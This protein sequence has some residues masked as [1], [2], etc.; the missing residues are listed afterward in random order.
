MTNL[1][2][3]FEPDRKNGRR[4]FSRLRRIP[5]RLL[6][7]NMVTLLALCAGLTSMR[8]AIEHR[9][10]L[11]IAAIAFA[12]ILDM[13]D[14]RIA[15]LLKSTS[16][17]GAELD[18]LADFV[19]FGVAPGIILYTFA[20]HEL[21]SLGWI[22]VLVLALATVLRLARFNV[23]LDA[24]PKPAWAQGFFV[25]VPAPAGAM[26]ALLP[27]YLELIGIPHLSLTAIVSSF[28]IMGVAFLMVSRLPTLSLK[29]T[30]DRVRR[31]MVLPIMIA[32]VMFVALLLSFPWTTLA[33]GSILYLAAIPVG[34]L[35]TAI[36]VVNNLRDR[37]GDARTGKRTLAVRLGA[38]GVRIE[39]SLLIAVA[40]GIPVYLF[41]LGLVGSLIFI[42]FVTFPAAAVLL[43]AVWVRDGATLNAALTGTAKL[44]LAFGLLFAL[45]ISVTT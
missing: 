14:G 30:G 2:P 11:A 18:S 6:V 36:L 7:P 26:I 35:A 21:K 43:R 17:F 28:Y 44:L 15:R 34:A 42:V 41:A 9:F 37:V 12:A 23:S 32:V 22:A 33:V 40:Y 31:D 38:T 27:I 20:L 39:Y 10:E 45:G 3:P 29:K 19:N 24:P 4:R 1:F 13:L 8:L 25:G 16:R 5:V